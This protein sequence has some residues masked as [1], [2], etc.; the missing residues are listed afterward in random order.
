MATMKKSKLTKKKRN[1]VGRKSREEPDDNDIDLE[2][3]DNWSNWSTCSVTCGQGKQVRWR[4]CISEDCVKGLKKAQL[5]NCRLKNYNKTT[6]EN[7]LMKR[8]QSISV[9]FVIFL[10]FAG[11][12][13]TILEMTKISSSII[14]AIAKNNINNTLAVKSNEFRQ[15]DY[16]CDI[17]NNNKEDNNI[18]F[19]ITRVARRNKEPKIWDRW[20][21]WSTCS[22]TCGVGKITRWRHCIGGSCSVGEKK[23]QLRTCTSAAC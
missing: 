18:Q 10:F 3:W 4:H 14:P 23:A 16:D 17:D 8:I 13:E 1:I 22:V 21:S 9:H 20:S 12:E 5:R 6:K 7:I 15:K 11:F 2:A 19:Q